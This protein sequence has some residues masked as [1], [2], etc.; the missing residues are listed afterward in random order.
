MKSF[1]IALF[2]WIA[3]V[4][5]L[6]QAGPAAPAAASDAVTELLN[7]LQDDAARQTIIA[8]IAR[9]GVAGPSDQA[10]APPADSAPATVEHTVEQMVS[11]WIAGIGG[12]GTDMLGALADGGRRVHDALATLGAAALSAAFWSAVGLSCAI[13][14]P[15]WALC[16]LMARGLRRSRW[17]AGRGV[18]PLLVRQLVFAIGVSAAL[19][20]AA[21]ALGG[22]VP[23]VIAVPDPRVIRAAQSA[24]VVFALVLAVLNLLPYRRPGYI[25]AG[26]AGAPAGVAPALH[27]WMIGTAGAMIY[28]QVWLIAVVKY[29]QEAQR[30]QHLYTLLTLSMLLWVAGSAFVCRRAGAAWLSRAGASGKVALRRSVFAYW[31]VPVWIYCAWVAVIALTRNGSVLLPVLTRTAYVIAIL[32]GVRLIRGGLDQIARA[33]VPLPAGLRAKAP[34]LKP[35]LDRLARSLLSLLRVGVCA[36]AVIWILELLDPPFLDP[37]ALASRIGA[38]FG[39]IEQVIVIAVVA[40]VIWIGF[41]SWAEYYTDPDTNAKAGARKRT[42]VTLFRNVVNIA[43]LVVAGMMILSELG[44]NIAPLLASAG[45]LG[46]AVGFGA[47]KLVQDVITGIFIQIEDVMQIGDTVTLGD[48]TGTV[49]RLTIRS[50]SLRDVEGNVH[51]MSFSQTDT[52]TNYQRDFA[53]AFLEV[54]LDHRENLE[55]VEAAM[56][57]A[58]VALQGRADVAGSILGDLTWFGVQSYNNGVMTIRV[59]IKTRPGDQWMVRRS[60]NACLKASFET[61]GIELGSAVSRIIL[62]RPLA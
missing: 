45:V 27:R 13:V 28:G 60:Y 40:A 31:Y 1:L 23:A 26:A 12:A 33:G 62:E 37:S 55:R 19:V 35:R 38:V 34:N 58:F 54:T 8:A 25:S 52:I 42:I 7:I 43:L 30:G 32:I 15:A 16:A 51:M 5:A 56:R 6:A 14:L 50:V 24:T 36:G 10:A 46:L 39:N 59:R 61:H 17:S 29:T 49:E 4:C 11:G 44:V 3:P 41:N 47:Q 20:V 2:L 21:Y 22:I 48:V 57:Q 9:S 53:Y 18:F